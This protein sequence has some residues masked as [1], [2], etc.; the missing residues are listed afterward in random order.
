MGMRK[1]SAMDQAQGNPVGPG[2]YEVSKQIGNSGFGK[3]KNKGFGSSG[4]T[5]F[6]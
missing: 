1:T 4:H 2:Q 6:G 5:G 3:V